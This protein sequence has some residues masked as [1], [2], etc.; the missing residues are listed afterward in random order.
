MVNCLVLGTN[1][2][3]PSITDTVSVSSAHFD[4]FPISGDTFVNE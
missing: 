4:I 1:G 3:A 2:I